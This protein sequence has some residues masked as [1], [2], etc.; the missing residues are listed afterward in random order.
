VTAE[1]DFLKKILYFQ[2]FS[3][4]E[5]N[6]IK[7]LVFEKKYERGDI[8][9]YEGEK[10]AAI[11]LVFS[12]A[13]KIFKTSVEGKEQILSIARPG[14]SFNEV[15]VFDDGFNPASAQAMGEVIIY[16][17]GKNELKA[18][19]Q[20][21]PDIAVN[22]IK[23]LAG[24]I[25]RL[26]TLVEDLSF[27]TVIGRVAKI[28]LEHAIEKEGA[29]PRLTQ[30]EMAAMAGSAREV[31]GRSLKALEEDGLIKLNRQK[32]SITDKKALREMVEEPV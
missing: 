13:V 17:L 7:P 23:V 24:Q 26:V 9:I 18:L 10:A 31:V 6:L 16:E 12:G 8:I 29:G 21:H 11:Y 27:R 15:P 3:F 25:R 14:D 22:M 28:L 1:Q 5:L 4:E 2:G 20:N 19:I 32:I 30:Q